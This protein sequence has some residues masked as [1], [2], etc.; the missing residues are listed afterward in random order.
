MKSAIALLILASLSSLPRNGQSAERLPGAILRT[1]VPARIVELTAHVKMRN[2]TATPVSRYIYRVTVPPSDLASQK[3]KLLSTT[4]KPVAL[5]RHKSGANDYLEFASPVSAMGTSNNTVTFR[6]LL[7]PVDHTRSRRSPTAL[8]PGSEAKAIAEYTKPSKM[9]ESD[10]PEVLE[11]ASRIFKS[12]SPAISAARQ[13]YEFPT[14]VLRFKL[15]NKNLG[16]QKGLQQGSG[17]C[18]E[19]ACLFAALCR[20]QSIPARRIAVFNFGKKR[21]I[22]VTQPNH[23]IAEVYIRNLGW[24]PVDANLGRG[25][26]D[27]PVGFGKLSNNMVVL[28]REGAWVTSTWFPPNSYPAALPKPKVT[29]EIS[30]EGKIVDEGDAQGLLKLFEKFPSIRS[31]K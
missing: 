7:L 21:A 18:T 9:I 27:R 25:Q 19:F 10:A 13:A 23:H 2:T 12:R 5:K 14:K 1:D 20:T 28:N 11:A 6:V 24:I 4:A 26:Y 29:F 15:Q 30:W 16:A 31:K 3:T 22:E 17:D 8:P